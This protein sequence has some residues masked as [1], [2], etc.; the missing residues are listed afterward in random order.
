[1]VVHAL[2][3]MKLTYPKVSDE[4]RHELEAARRELEGGGK[5]KKP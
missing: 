1:V 2:E 4:K 5:N 3:E